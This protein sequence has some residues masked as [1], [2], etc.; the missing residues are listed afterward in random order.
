M[1]ITQSAAIEQVRARLAEET[2]GFFTD[3]QIRAWLNDGV[4]EVARRSLWKRTSSSVSV[5]AGTQFYT[6]PS[7]AIQISRVEYKAST[8]NAIYPL[9][10]RD[11]NAMDV[12]WGINQSIGR[13]TPEYYTLVSANPLSIELCPTPGVGGTLKVYY[14][15]MPTD[16]TV[17]A[18]TDAATNLDVPVGWEDLP[19]EWATGMGFRKSRD[20]NA[21]QLAVAVFAQQL[22][23]LTEMATRYT[24][25]PTGIV[26]DYGWYGGVA[27]DY[28][29]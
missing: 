20:V 25:S 12:V 1:T 13:G 15:A 21:Y 7:T 10:Y 23:R 18:N 2:P 17:N 4:R 6:A 16:L 11:I 8:S 27:L 9:E 29:F 22:D 14:Y 19:V 26:P 24:D 3:S 5:V 28:G